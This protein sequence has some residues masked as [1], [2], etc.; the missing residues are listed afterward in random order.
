MIANRITQARRIAS[1]V[2]SKFVLTF[3]FPESTVAGGSHGCV[4]SSSF[5]EIEIVPSSRGDPKKKSIVRRAQS[6]K[7]TE[8]SVH[9]QGF[10]AERGGST[11][12][13]QD[14]GGKR[15]LRNHLPVR[16]S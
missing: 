14:V 5:A 6:R 9:L 16:L 12:C 13:L 1:P 3:R 15:K 4:Y 2:E 10:V 11:P 7:A 8:Q